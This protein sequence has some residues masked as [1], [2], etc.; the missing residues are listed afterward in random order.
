MPLTVLTRRRGALS[1]SLM[2]QLLQPQL[3]NLQTP[4]RHE[5]LDFL[6]FKN[7]RR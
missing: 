3:Q 5:C 6:D 7:R 4:T 1:I 2:V